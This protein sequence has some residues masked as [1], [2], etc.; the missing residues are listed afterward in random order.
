MQLTDRVLLPATI[1]YTDT[2]SG[3][4][5][6]SLSSADVTSSV[7]RSTAEAGDNAG[8]ADSDDGAGSD[9]PKTVDVCSLTSG[10]P[11]RHVTAS[12]DVEV[13]KSYSTTHHGGQSPTDRVSVMTMSLVNFT[14]NCVHE[15]AA[16][17][18][19]AS[20]SSLLRPL[21]LTSMHIDSTLLQSAADANIVI[22]DSTPADSTHCT[23]E[24][25]SSSRT[26]SHELSNRDDGSEVQ[27]H[28][29][30]TRYLITT[31]CFIHSV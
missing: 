4:H 13:N 12:G 11:A 18:N 16:E 24:L 5:S 22:T 6:A 20:S 10:D 17:D 9:E 14:S 29:Q 21:P 27:Q 25:Q 31:S 2:G 15:A 8:S 3:Q 23:D 19:S 30:W 26:N 28:A 1:S 7:D